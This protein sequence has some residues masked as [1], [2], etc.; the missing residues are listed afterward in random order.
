MCSTAESQTEEIIAR[1]WI[2]RT[3]LLATGS[4]GGLV[5]SSYVIDTVYNLFIYTYVVDS[6]DRQGETKLISYQRGGQ[7]LFVIM[8]RHRKYRFWLNGGEKC[9]IHPSL[10]DISSVDVYTRRPVK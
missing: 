8:A 2:N 1:D 4:R 10:V 9:A 5:W 7:H 3:P 6:Q